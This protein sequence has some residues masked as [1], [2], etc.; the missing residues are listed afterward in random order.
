M[1]PS[2]AE[3]LEY[4][5]QTLN[6][7][8][9]SRDCI[10]IQE[11]KEFITSSEQLYQ[12]TKKGDVN[13]NLI[14]QYNKITY[15]FDDLT[16]QKLFKHLNLIRKNKVNSHFSERQ[17][18][19]AQPNTGIMLDYDMYVTSATAQIDERQLHRIS[20]QIVRYLYTDLDFNTILP[21]GSTNRNSTIVNRGDILIKVFNIV[22]SKP[23]FIDKN[24]YK[25][26]IHV[27]ILL[28]IQKNYLI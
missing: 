6:N 17:G 5:I 9:N 21:D 2:P 14:D 13:T 23:L 8:T 19:I 22:K 26:G 20:S 11:F 18:T 10:S 25:Y 3:T 7:E 1:F 27:L 28:M 4:T 16:I 15:N 24:K 12:I